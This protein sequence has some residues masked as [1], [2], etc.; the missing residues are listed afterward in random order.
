MWSGLARP[1]EAHIVCQSKA[2]TLTREPGFCLREDQFS[3]T[4]KQRGSASRFSKVSEVANGGRI[5]GSEVSGDQI[6]RLKTK[7]RWGCGV[8]ASP[9]A[10]W[11]L[12]QGA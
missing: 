6:A 7:P 4:E 2:H 8:Y 10:C 12:S 1:T 5:K 3:D 11:G 9:E